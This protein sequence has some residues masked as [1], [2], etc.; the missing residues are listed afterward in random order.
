MG[1]GTIAAASLGGIF[2]GFMISVVGGAIH[3]PIATIAAPLVCRGKVSVLSRSF[4]YRPGQRGV[5]HN[6]VCITGTE[7]AVQELDITVQMVAASAVL[8]ALASFVILLPLF[9]LLKNVV[10]IET[11]PSR[12]VRT[13]AGVRF[14]TSSSASGGMNSSAR[15]AQLKHLHDAGHISDAE[16]EQKRREILAEL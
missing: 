15:M 7:P 5:S 9:N 4:S 3:P 13:Q 12:T 8:Y 1:K 14:T 11:V 6:I 16:Y 10:E 2:T